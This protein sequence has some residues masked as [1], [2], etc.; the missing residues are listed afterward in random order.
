MEPTASF[1]YWVRRRRK[2]LDLTQEELARQV[3]CAAI[4]IKKIEADERRPSRQIAE[5]LADRL[6][7]APAERAA[8]V[9]AARGE[10]ATD[11]LD[12]PAPPPPLAPAVARLP[13]GTI[14]FLC[15][16]IA[17]SSQLWEQHPE[18]MRLALARHDT[19]L[20][21]TIAAHEGIVFKSGGDGVYAAFRRVPDALAA[22]VAAQQA[23]LAEPWGETGPLHVRMALHMGVAEERDGDYFGPPLNRAARLLAAGHGDQILLSRATQELVCDTLPPDVALRDLGTHRLKDLTRPEHIFQVVAPALPVDFP[24]LQTLDTRPHN[25]PA[26]LTPLIGRTQEV[27]AVCARMRRDDVRLLTLTGS[28][29][30]GKTRLALQVAAELLEDFVDGAC[31][32]DLVPIS[33]PA[34]VASTIAQPLGVP[35]IGDQPLLASLKAH[36]KRKQQLLV[37]DNFEQVFSAAP[38][39]VELLAAA[40]KLKVLITS[41]A[42]LH[43]SG[44]HEFVVPPLA[45]PNRA[46]PPPLER[47]IQYDAVRLFI[48]RAQAVKADFSVT[49]DTAPAIAEICARLDGLPLAIELA[50]AR[51]KLFAPQA[52]LVRLSSRLKLLTGGARDLPIRQQT[53]RS[54]IDWS[55]NL[56]TVG[57]QTLFARL[58]VFVGGCTLEAAEAVAS[59][60]KIENEKLKKDRDDRSFSIFNSQFSILD[61][62]A[63]LVDQSLVRREEPGGEPRFTMLET[64]R[65]YALERLEA[66]GEA[67]VVRRRHAEFFLGWAEKFERFGR[68][69]RVLTEPLETDL[70][71]FRAALAGG[72]AEVAARSAAALRYFWVMRGYSSEGRRWLEAALERSSALPA[73][74]RAKALAAAGSLAWSQDDEV[75]AT[76]LFEESLEMFRAQDDQQGIA[77][78]LF[79]LGCIVYFQSDQARATTLLTESLE[80][81]RAQDDQQGI[82]AAIKRLGSVVMEQGDKTRAAALLE[83]SLARFRDLGDKVEIADALHILAGL[84]RLQG[85]E[86]RALALEQESLALCRELGFKSL[87][88]M[89]L[90]GMGYITQRQGDAARA[91]G[92][93]AEALALCREMRRRPCLTLC[94]A[95]L[96]GVA[97]MV[98][99]PERAARLFGAAEALGE[100]FDQPWLRGH[101]IEWERNVVTAR[102]QLDEATFAAAWAAGQAMTPEQAIAYALEGD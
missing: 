35:E 51:I 34:L 14:T 84:T 93:F 82:A 40:P 54:T 37:L 50:A 30:A 22:A 98:R 97:G 59:E 79:N 16:D 3:G 92:C 43:V 44:E 18:A 52:L 53:L 73:S 11:R 76:A 66:S 13:G 26:Q 49:S 23:L 67:D 33:D 95:G 89:V 69:Q 20:R 102:A 57:E 99:Q 46:H 47:L 10:L 36:L 12:V 94:L 58:A 64:I 85:D 28:G 101:R 86:A 63:A 81:F 60:L 8:F 88:P 61:G 80:M 24:S 4:T 17:G 6:Q 7:L 41:R 68:S 96:A 75:R 19:I 42:V 15:T 71:N 32:V 100:A 87:L 91:R 39:V 77:W 25:L 83:E 29:G 62:L 5:R 55:Y 31:F 78:T 27:A 56:L 90:I 65:E 48:E 70:D 74:A 1:G 21:E 9:Q 45:L 2:A 72:S 38:L